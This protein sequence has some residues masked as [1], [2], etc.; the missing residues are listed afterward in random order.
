MANVTVSVTIA[1]ADVARTKTALMAYTGLGANASAKQL[2][3]AALKQ[4]VAW[5]ERSAITINEPSIE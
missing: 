4:L 1:E 5:Q 2:A 3:A